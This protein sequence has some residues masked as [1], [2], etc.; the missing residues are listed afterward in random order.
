[1]TT[2]S[3]SD[4]PAYSQLIYPA[5]KAIDELGG[6]G[7]AKEI[8]AQVLT[9]IGASEEQLSITY[10]NRSKSVLLDRI[11][12]AL[13]YAKQGKILESPS[14]ALYVLAPAGR[15]ILSLPADAAETKIKEIDRQVRRSRSKRTGTPLGDT[16][17]SSLDTVDAEEDNED[18][19]Q[20][21]EV[22]LN[23]LH[24]LSPAGFEEF[25][26]FLLKS[27]DME[28]TRVGGSGDEGKRGIRRH[29][30]LGR[31]QARHVGRAGLQHGSQ[32][33][34]KATAHERRPSPGLGDGVARQ[35]A[36]V[37]TVLAAT[38]TSRSTVSGK[39]TNVRPNVQL[40][41]GRP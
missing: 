34:G 41:G 40:V 31:R 23:R 24:Q 6:S 29:R 8:V 3:R 12:W 36:R 38:M 37:C 21:K 17:A 2:L 35:P 30:P 19:T 7:K 14:R 26:I 5:L 32:Q 22:L 13:T 4:L 11:A 16:E 27:F 18:D 1:M 28:L 15:T 33:Q 25:V 20:W 9:D 39:R 10:E